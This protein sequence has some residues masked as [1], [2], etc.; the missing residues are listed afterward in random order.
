MK[1][2]LLI[3]VILLVSGSSVYATPFLGV[4][5]T[6][7]YTV[8]DKHQVGDVWNATYG[9]YSAANPEIFTGSYLGTFDG[10]TD[11]DKGYMLELISYYLDEPI[12]DN[13]LKYDVGT[14]SDTGVLSISMNTDMKAGEWALK[15]TDPMNNAVNFYAVK[16]STSFALYYIDPAATSGFWTTAHIENNGGNIPTISHLSVA[17][18][19][20]LPVPEPAT[21]F[22][23]GVG[24]VSLAGLRRKL[25]K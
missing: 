8:I 5:N 16:A 19:A 24:L 18:T 23:L 17:T 20:A 9:G 11:G 22:L 6:S 21:M 4:P 13:L 25:V 15:S 2:I 12:G 1:K 14:S 10:N 7:G 3:L